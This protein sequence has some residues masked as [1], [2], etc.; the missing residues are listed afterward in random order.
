MAPAYSRTSPRNLVHN[1]FFQL[2]NITSYIDDNFSF[3]PCA[4]DSRPLVDLEP[5][6]G[7]VPD[8]E[9]VQVVVGVG[10]LG[11][12]EKISE[13]EKKEYKRS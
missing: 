5:A 1:F 4:D 11:L 12:W 2:L 7:A 10:I 8:E 3:L 9:V 6:P 13:R